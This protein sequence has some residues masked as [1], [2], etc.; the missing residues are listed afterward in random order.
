MKALVIFILSAFPLIANAQDDGKPYGNR[1]M[2][3]VVFRQGSRTWELDAA[4][5]SNPALLG[6][7]IACIGPSV[8]VRN[9]YCLKEWAPGIALGTGWTAGYGEASEK[10]RNL[11][12]TRFCAGPLVSVHYTAAP[13]LDIYARAFFCMDFGGVF[14]MEKDMDYKRPAALQFDCGLAVG[15]AYFF[16]RK[17]GICIESGL[18]SHWL[19]AGIVLSFD[20]D[21]RTGLLG[22]TPKGI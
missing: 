3:D 10:K 18:Q 20:R 13:R 9:E 16:C 14:N 8:R 22:R 6:K 5:F 1:H 17:I 15:I 12:W 2:Y 7:K 4:F 21:V 19:G 11:Q